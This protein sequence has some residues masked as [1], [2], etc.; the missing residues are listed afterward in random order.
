M[1]TM[2]FR[3]VIVSVGGRLL[4]EWSLKCHISAT[5][6]VCTVLPHYT[7]QFVHLVGIMILCKINT[8]V[9]GGS[10]LL[11]ALKSWGGKK[12][13]TP[14]TNHKKKKKKK[15][16]KKKKKKKKK[17]KKNPSHPHCM[18]VVIWP[19][20]VQSALRPELGQSSHVGGVRTAVR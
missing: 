10:P 11:I 12:K 9:G 2:I 1:L 14:Q 7:L 18:I 8:F 17:I 15:Q 19:V 3:R 4:E 5:K 16:K 13:N 6:V 20:D